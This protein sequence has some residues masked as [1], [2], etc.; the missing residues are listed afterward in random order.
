MPE[1]QTKKGNL[2]KQDVLHLGKILVSSKSC[3]CEK[4]VLKIWHMSSAVKR[5]NL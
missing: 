2:V 4:S 1:N 5:Y 3:G